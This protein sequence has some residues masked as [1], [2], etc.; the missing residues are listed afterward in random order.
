MRIT[1]NGD[2]FEL[3]EPLTVDRLLHKLKV[4]SR[5]VAVEYNLVV[6]RRAHFDVTLVKPGD[7]IEIVN[8]V[9]GG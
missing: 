8:F 5:R 2:P 3:T 9:G 1:L 7:Q 4:D 6:L